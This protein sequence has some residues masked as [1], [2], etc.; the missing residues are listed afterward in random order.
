MCKSG[1]EFA[2]GLLVPMVPGPLPVPYLALIWLSSEPPCEAQPAANKPARAT[3][4]INLFILFSLL[5]YLL[6][7]S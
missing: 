1:F 6:T 5:S 3:N 7:S 2:A 4:A